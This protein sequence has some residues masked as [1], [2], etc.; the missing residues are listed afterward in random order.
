MFEIALRLDYHTNVFYLTGTVFGYEIQFG[1]GKN[2][3]NG[4]DP[5]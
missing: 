5:E 3:D 4:R 2:I 1:T